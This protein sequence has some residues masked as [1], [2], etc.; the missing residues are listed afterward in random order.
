MT[1][2]EGENRV[3][4]FYQGGGNEKV[5]NYP[6]TPNSIVVDLG[7]HEG[8]YCFEMFKRYHCFVFGLDA[9]PQD[10]F[11]NEIGNN[12][13]IVCVPYGL[14]SSDQQN[15]VNLF[16]NGDATSAYGSSVNIYQGTLKPI[17]EFFNDYHLNHIDLI[18]INIEGG[19]YDL[20]EHWIRTNVVLKIQ[21][22]Q[23]Q[24]HPCVSNY[25]ERYKGIVQ[26]LEKTHYRLYCFPWV[27]ESWFLKFYPQ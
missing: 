19:E 18:N 10:K 2:K 7:A 26:N 1:D 6:L 9:C 14:S 15:K 12:S 11:N 21:F 3:A 13:K 27:W 22:I 20:L 25:E 8:Q 16:V 5:Y 4:L 17:Q 23:I 24:F